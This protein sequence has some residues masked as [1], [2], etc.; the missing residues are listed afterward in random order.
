MDELR[1]KIL[2]LDLDEYLALKKR[3]KDCRK[4]QYDKLTEKEKIIFDDFADMIDAKIADLASQ[5]ADLY[6]AAVEE[7]EFAAHCF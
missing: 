1:E 4:N 3:L 2:D 6:H 7:A 5:L